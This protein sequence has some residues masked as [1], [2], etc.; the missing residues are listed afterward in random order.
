MTSDEL[1]THYRDYISCLNDRRLDR[2]REFYADELLYNGQRLTR[3]AWLAQAIEASFEAMPDLQWR[4]QH[5]VVD[6]SHVAARLLDTGTPQNA[7]SGLPPNPR[8]RT[9]SFGEHV[10]Y[11][12]REGLAE[13]VWSIAD[14]EAIR[15]QITQ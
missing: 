15:T 8:G 2:M 12:F 10:F 1:D 13:E 9:A 6:G 4:I 14:I 5:L 11:R 3:S 7:W